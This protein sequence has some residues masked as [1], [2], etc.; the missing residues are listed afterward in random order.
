MD[1]VESQKIQYAVVCRWFEQAG[2][3][4]GEAKG[5]GPL[6]TTKSTHNPPLVVVVVTY[7]CA[8][9]RKTKTF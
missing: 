4:V 6:P 1:E 8:V 5:P 2:P 3:G 9:L 7:I